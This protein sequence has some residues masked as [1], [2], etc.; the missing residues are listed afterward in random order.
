MVELSEVVYHF[1]CSSRTDPTTSF[2]KMSENRWDQ[3]TIRKD[4]TDSRL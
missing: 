1:C 3:A 2:V 4:A